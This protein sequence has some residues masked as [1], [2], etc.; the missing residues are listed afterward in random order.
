MNVLFIGYLHGIGGAQRQVVNVANAMSRMG[1]NVTLV[2]LSDNKK[3]YEIDPGVKK[4]H[5]KDFGIGPFRIV[6]RYFGLRRLI[7]RVKPDIVVNFWF[8]SAYLTTLMKWRMHFKNIYSERSDP[9]D[10]QYHGLLGVVR[11]IT[12]NKI[13][14]FVFQTNAAKEY[15]DDE[16]Q[17]RSVIIPNPVSSYEALNDGGDKNKYNIVSV[18]RLHE[19]KNFQLLIEAFDMIKDKL[20]KYRLIIYGEGEEE[21]NLRTIISKKKLEKKIILAGKSNNV[22]EDIRGSA[23]FVLSSNYEGMPNALLEA[24]SLGIPCISTNWSPGGVFD[25]ITNRESGVIVERNN[26]EELAKAILEVIS[27]A[28]L[29]SKIS[30]NSKRIM[31]EKYNPETIFRKWEGFFKEIVGDMTH[32]E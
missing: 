32:E 14:G 18:G 4:Y 20:S 30:L 29:R 11:K 21:Q 5:V 24:M 31:V 12:L 13:D 10:K 25:I 28:D 3:C 15:F 16:V 9:G 8:Q 26:K 6:S 17:S 27:D 7:K 22:Q 2:S 23:L 1:H 19:Q